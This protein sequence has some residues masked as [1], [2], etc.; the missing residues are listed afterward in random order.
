MKIYKNQPISFGRI[1]IKQNNGINFFSELIC[2]ASDNKRTKHSAE[3]IRTDSDSVYNISLIDN[4]NIK[5]A[6]QRIV[7]KKKKKILY[8]DSL[9]SSCEDQGLGTCLHL[10]NTIE[11]LEN[12]IEKMALFST[13]EAIPFHTRFGF[14]P[15]NEWLNGLGENIK[16]IAKDSTP[17]LKDYSDFAKQLKSCQISLETKSVL[18]NRLLNEYTLSAIKHYPKNQLKKLFKYPTNMELSLNDIYKNKEKYNL[19]F[20]KYN[21]DYSID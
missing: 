15:N 4:K 1:N 8:I 19:L 10:I 17:E 7:K 18:G 14:I 3:I 5:N 2:N 6:S 12:G 11:M 16:I 9:S 20:K 21:I 13:S